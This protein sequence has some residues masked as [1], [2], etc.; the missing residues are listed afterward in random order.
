M[1]GKGE[2]RPSATD[3]Q[4]APVAAEGFQTPVIGGFRLFGEEAAGKALVVI[5]V[6]RHAFAAFAVSGTI[7]GTGTGAGIVAANGM[8]SVHRG[9]ERS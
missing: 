1:S 5:P 6:M 7:V 2:P 4:E 3:G 9:I 8:T